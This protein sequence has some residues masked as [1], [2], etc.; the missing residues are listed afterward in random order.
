MSCAKCGSSVIHP[1]SGKCSICSKFEAVGFYRYMT[2][3]L[4]PDGQTV[5]AGTLFPRME[6]PFEWHV[7]AARRIDE[8]GLKVTGSPCKNHGHVG[9]INSKGKCQLCADIKQAEEDAARQRKRDELAARQA[10]KHAE[11]LES[12]EERRKRNER[13]T[14]LRR[15][16]AELQ[17]E[18]ATLDRRYGTGNSPRQ[19]AIEAG[20]KWYLPDE[21]CGK[22]GQL[23]ERYVANGKC[24][25]C[26]GR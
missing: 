26:A 20:E 17:A 1:M 24:R 11:N 8:P 4:N 13:I 23:A 25:G 12:L 7:L 14:E 10:R 6:I 18:L 3:Q 16:M 21:P 5:N 2:G 15:Q 22:C 9:L 19:R